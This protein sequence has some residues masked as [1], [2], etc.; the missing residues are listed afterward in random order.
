MGCELRESQET[1]IT[2][3]LGGL[4]KG[5][6]VMIEHQPFVSLDDVIK[7]A[8][9][10]QRQREYG[11]LTTPRVFN[12]KPMIAGSTL[13]GHFTSEFPNWREVT[14]RNPHAIESEVEKAVEDVCGVTSKEKVEYV[15]E[16]EKLKAQQVVSSKS[17]LE[18][19]SAW[20]TFRRSRPQR[21]QQENRIEARRKCQIRA[22]REAAED[23]NRRVTAGERREQIASRS[24]KSPREARVTWRTRF[25]KATTRVAD[26][27]TQ[28]HNRI[29]GER[30]NHSSQRFKAHSPISH[31]PHL[32]SIIRPG[33]CES[34]IGKAGPSRYRALVGACTGFMMAYARGR[35][36][37]HTLC[38]AR[39]S[40]STCSVVA[41]CH[42]LGSWNM[43]K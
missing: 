36:E 8:I 6:A 30:T 24:I 26:S 15:D 28:Q 10:V 11:Q 41:V 27:K 7:L 25:T 19:G 9:K 14:I 31:Q 35:R 37:V 21:S 22:A 42:F 5:I 3:L 16:G 39:G 2:R 32:F 29:A 4:N 12:M 43:E 18:S 13:Q 34:Q 23:Q 20:R 33:A 17:K 1:T 38:G 40:C